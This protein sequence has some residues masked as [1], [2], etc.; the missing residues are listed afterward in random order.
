[1][2][3][4]W[5]TT[6]SAF[7]DSSFFGLG[8]WFLRGSRDRGYLLVGWGQ[9]SWSIP[10]SAQGKRAGIPLLFLRAGSGQQRPGQP[11]VTLHV[12]V[13][14]QELTLEQKISQS[15]LLTCTSLLA[16]GG[17]T[18][19]GGANLEP[20]A[21]SVTAVQVVI[22]SLALWSPFSATHPACL[23]I[24]T[25]VQSEYRTM[26]LNS[27]VT[28]VYMVVSTCTC[29]VKA[30][31]YLPRT[32]R[33]TSKPRFLILMEA[34]FC[35]WSN[36]PCMTDSLAVGLFI[37]LWL[38]LSWH[39]QMSCTAVAAWTG[40]VLGWKV[41]GF[42]SWTARLLRVPGMLWRQVCTQQHRD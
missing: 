26:C 2:L 21:V 20:I 4:L 34:K 27:V 40:V 6:L 14:F 16:K 31:F 1:M 8:Y 39:R 13:C 36:T 28:C 18:T 35:R 19:T 7:C 23:L 10:T 41:Q 30:I 9:K 25:G 17:S 29:I 42:G 3:L 37:L 12:W 22:S 38:H 11:K 33:A 24:L 32:S 5:P 15:W